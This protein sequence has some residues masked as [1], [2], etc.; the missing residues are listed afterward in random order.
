MGEP[1]LSGIPEFLD[2][3][4]LPASTDLALLHTEFMPEHLTIDMRD[5]RRLTGLF[6]FEPAMIGDPAYD[7]VNAGLFVTRGDPRQ[8]RRFYEAYGAHRTTRTNCSPTR[9]CTC[10]ATC[11]S[12]WTSFR[13]LPN[14]HRRTRELW[15]G[16]KG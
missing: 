13:P 9:C 11:P 7:F 4:P 15:F 1:W 14:A 6:D 16:T 10:T 8:L 5:G 3:V 2:S 12:V